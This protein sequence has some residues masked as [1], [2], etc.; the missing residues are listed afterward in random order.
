ML[1]YT[2]MI[3]FKA[4]VTLFNTSI[5]LTA[6]SSSPSVNKISLKKQTSPLSIM[7]EVIKPNEDK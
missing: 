6:H 5:I 1:S 4:P 2:T 7:S 3:K